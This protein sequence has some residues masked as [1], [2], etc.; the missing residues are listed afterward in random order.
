MS[1]LKYFKF[2]QPAWPTTMTVNVSNQ[3]G[4]HCWSP[5][6][7]RR[8]SENTRYNYGKILIWQ[9]KLGEARS[10][11]CITGPDLGEA[12]ASVPQWLRRLWCVLY[13]RAPTHSA[14]VSHKISEVTGPNFH[15]SSRNFYQKQRNFSSS[16]LW[17]WLALRQGYSS[18]EEN[19]APRVRAF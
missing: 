13:L 9:A 10:I 3:T 19:I 18:H 6:I 5:N 14:L 1:L 4:C 15:Q 2:Q 12:R 11:A 16:M 7:N 8:M 17:P